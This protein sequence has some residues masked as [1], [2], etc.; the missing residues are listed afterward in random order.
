M[1]AA[2]SHR[3][4]AGGEYEFNQIAAAASFNKA[5]EHTIYFGEHDPKLDSPTTTFVPS[6]DWPH[7]ITMVELLANLPVWGCLVNSDIVVSPDF[8]RV[9][10][11]LRE[12]SME[13]AVSRRYEFDPI[14]PVKPKAVVDNGLDIF[15]AIPEVWGHCAREIPKAFRIGHQRWDTWMIGFMNHHYGMK[16][17]DFTRFKV[18]FHPKH[19]GRKFGHEITAEIPWESASFGMPLSL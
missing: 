3:K 6:E 8:G 9:E 16:F 1:I 10:R 5:F 18:I 11:A 15:C 12:Q 14:N 19:D 7:I 17:R 2:T 13:C 4:L